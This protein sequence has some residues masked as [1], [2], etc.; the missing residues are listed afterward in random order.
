MRILSRRMANRLRCVRSWND[1]RLAGVK[2]SA[3]VLLTGDGAMTSFSGIP[4]TYTLARPTLATAIPRGG[5]S[6]YGIRRLI[7]ALRRHDGPCISRLCDGRNG[8]L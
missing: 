7:R 2:P 4:N 5:R 3:T 6:W 8:A 1:Q